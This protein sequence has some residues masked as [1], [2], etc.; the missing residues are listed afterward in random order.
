MERTALLYKFVNSISNPFKTPERNLS[1]FVVMVI[2]SH[3]TLQTL[4]EFDIIVSTY[5][6]EPIR[7]NR[8]I[9]AHR[10]LTIIYLKQ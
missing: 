3:S 2:V 4:C 10:Y 5:Y 6:F 9:T 1:T 7:N 8:L